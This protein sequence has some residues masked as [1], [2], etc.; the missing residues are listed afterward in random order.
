MVALCRHFVCRIGLPLEWGGL[1]ATHYVH[2]GNYY[3]T[4]IHS[5]SLYNTSMEVFRS[6]RSL[7]HHDHVDT[8][9]THL[10][11]YNMEVRAYVTHRAH[12]YTHGVIKR[13]IMYSLCVI[14]WIGSEDLAPDWG[15]AGSEMTSEELI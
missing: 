4:L 6:A 11:L 12:H 9:A 8:L 13:V 15:P 7:H 14:T 10:P 2:H 3:I 1:L 5:I